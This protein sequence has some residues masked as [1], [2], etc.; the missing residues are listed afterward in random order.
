MPDIVA[1]SLII[2]GILAIIA[3][4]CLWGPRRESPLEQAAVRPE[5]VIELGPANPSHDPAVVSVKQLGDACGQALYPAV[6]ALSR[7]ANPNPTPRE[8]LQAANIN[9][10]TKGR[11]MADC[12]AACMRQNRSLQGTANVY[13]YASVDS[14][15][16]AL[17]RYGYRSNGQRKEVPND[18]A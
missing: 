16:K 15:R 2:A 14:M 8:A 12:V 3:L 6:E 1:V 17:S 13:G 7:C 10:T 4:S 11:L 18:P 5:R 9:R